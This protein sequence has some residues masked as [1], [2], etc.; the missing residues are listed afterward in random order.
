MQAS[1]KNIWNITFPVLLSIM[2]EQ[3]ISMTD[4]A[5]LGRLGEVELGASALAATYYFIFYVIGS[6]F[7]VGAQILLA[8]MNGEKSYRQINSVFLTS[9][10]FLIG[11]ATLIVL[12][13]KIFS[14]I[15]LKWFISADD[16]YAATISY[17][18]WRIYGLFFSFI[19]VIFRSFFVAVTHTRILTISSIIMVV[20]NIICNYTLIFGKF[21]FPPLGIAGAAIGSTFAEFVAT[22]FLYIYIRRK[23]SYKKYNLFSTIHF[24]WGLL[25]RILNMSIWTMIQALLSLSTWF[26]FFIMI[27]HLGK[28]SLA[29]GNIIRNISAIPFIFTMAFATTINSLTSNLIGAGY[30]EQISKLCK[31]VIVMCF[32]F[33]I[34]II[35]LACV[36]P[37]F[38]LSIYTDNQVL[39]NA[40]IPTLY[41]MLF[42]HL[43]SGPAFIMNFA[44]SGT[45]NSKAASLLELGTLAIYVLYI[46]FVTGYLKQNITVSWT[47]EYIYGIILLAGS[48]LYMRKGKWRN[49]QI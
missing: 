35:L 19:L 9:G 30:Q 26:V 43:T 33:I 4:T 42:A 37:R 31:K 45:G 28:T 47:A 15:I 10:I 16:I 29:I 22:L 8:R 48:V 25:K 27:E 11:L 39:I 6:G 2:V 21:G 17:M 20:I 14:P 49:K 18:D 44:V 3:L 5:F 13:S 41:V 36:F 1:Y 38:F 34:P 7:G 24:Q 23:A 12:S 46:S 40:A 32:L